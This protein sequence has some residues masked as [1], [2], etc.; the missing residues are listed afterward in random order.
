MKRN[1]KEA[2]DFQFLKKYHGG[3]EAG[4]D[5]RESFLDFGIF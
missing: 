3:G 5:M 4:A 2:G 1:E